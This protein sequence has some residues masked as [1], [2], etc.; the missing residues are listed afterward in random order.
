MQSWTRCYVKIEA[1]K[2]FPCYMK[3]SFHKNAKDIDN[4]LV[5]RINIPGLEI[6]PVSV[7]DDNKTSFDDIL[8]ISKM[9]SA[10]TINHDKRNHS[11]ENPKRCFFLTKLFLFL[12]A[13]V[14]LPGAKGVLYDRHSSLIVLSSYLSPI[15]SLWQ[16]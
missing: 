1:I 6:Y 5:L 11:S 14:C 3:I 9:P 15:Y 4:G 7:N 13:F 10:I 12:S 16:Q 8:S 2:C